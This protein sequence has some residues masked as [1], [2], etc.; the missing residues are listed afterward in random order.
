MRAVKSKNTAPEV[1]LRKALF[2]LGFRY[3][4]HSKFLPG[5]PDIVFRKKKKV[6]FVNGCFWHG[7]SCKRGSRMPKTNV[8][9]WQKKIQNN[10]TRDER[11]LGLI[12]GEGWSAFVV[13]ECELK[14]IELL[15][16]KVIQFLSS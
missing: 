2:K 13:W 5:S 16:P 12:N 6:I 9:Y 7:H 1:L 3:R 4:L 10:R 14:E 8:E 11:N 15:I